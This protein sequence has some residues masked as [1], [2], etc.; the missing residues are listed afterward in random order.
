M[1]SVR[2]GH[3]SRS[4]PHSLPIDLERVVSV[5]IA[6]AGQPFRLRL[7]RDVPSHAG[8]IDAQRPRLAAQQLA[9]AFALEPA[10]QV[11]ECCV[12]PNREVATGS[13]ADISGELGSRTPLLIGLRDAHARTER[14]L[15]SNATLTMR[16]DAMQVALG[17]MQDAAG[18]LGWEALAALGRSDHTSLRNVQISAAATLETVVRHLNTSVSGRFLFSGTLVESTPV[19]TGQHRP[20]SSDRSSP[21][22]PPP[23]AGRSMSATWRA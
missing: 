11:P 20:A 6:Q 19:V 17:A 10:A 9:D 3:A 12:Q 7:G 5:A 16:L 1:A 21:T 18:Q 8:G 14:Y 15:Q 22:P 4:W 23:R 13:K 2:P